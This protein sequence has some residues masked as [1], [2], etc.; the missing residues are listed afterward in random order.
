MKRIVPDK[1]WLKEESSKRHASS[2]CPYANSYKCPRYYD[3]VI[4]FS[5]LHIIDG[6]PFNKKNEL[7]QFWKSTSFSSLCNEEIPNIS[8]NDKGGIYSIDN[9]CPEISFKYLGYYADYMSKY[10]DEHDQSIG[11]NIAKRDDIENDWK[12]DWMTVNPVFYEDCTLFERVKTFDKESH[13]NYYKR[14]HPN[15]VIQINRMDN[16]LDLNDPTGALHAASNI[17]ETMAKEIVNSPSILNKSLGSFF[18]KFEKE[19]KLPPALIK[20]VKDIYDLRNK[21]STAGHGGLDKPELTLV[22]AIMI[23]AIVKAIVEIEYRNLNI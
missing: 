11:Q 18:A 2:E 6:M 21:L 7:E 23:A 19:S 20:A 16:C 14:L 8:K 22:D 1:K 10:V 3:S 13:D 4:L 15:I 5:R 9:F 12:Y 17:L